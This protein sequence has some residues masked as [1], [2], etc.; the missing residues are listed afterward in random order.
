MRHEGLV[1]SYAHGALDVPLSDKT[2]GQV[3]TETAAR[4]ADRLAVVARHQAVRRTYAEFYADIDRLAC[5][6]HALGIRKGERVGIWSPN[7]Y[8]WLLVQFATS[9]LGIILVNVNPA[10]RVFE[11]EYALNKSGVRTLIAAPRFRT[12][13][14][15]AMLTELCPELAA[16]PAGGAGG[17]DGSDG[18]ARFA[19]LPQLR[20]VVILGDSA[21]PGAITWPDLLARA[22]ATE[23]ATVAAIAAQLQFDDP[24]NIQYTSGTTGFPKGVTLS[25]HNIVNNARYVGWAQRITAD[26]RICIP[27]PFY[28]C[29]GMVLSNMVA[30]C[31]GA[32]MIIPGEAFDPLAVLEA[33]AAERCT[34]LQGVPTMF[35]AELE[36]PEF[37][38]FDL[39]SLRTGIMAGAPCP[40]ELVRRVIDKMHMREFTIAYGQTELSPVVTQTTWDDPPDVRATT[41]GRPAPQAEIKIVDPVTGKVVPV[42]AQG[43]ICCRGYH[44]MLG[45]WDDPEA[46]ANTIDSSGWLHTG[47]L[48]TMDAHGYVKITGRSKEMVIRGGE[49]IY[50]RE[51]EEF[52]YTHPAIAEV[53]CFGVPD[54]KYGEEVCAWIHLRAGAEATA[55][56]I[57]AFCR[58]KI[59]TYKIPRYIKFVS[60]FPMTVT[61]KIQKFKMRAAMID[62]LG[63]TEAADIETA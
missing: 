41:V 52:L 45:Y 42:G 55:D 22:A 60:E 4:F 61:G 58:G 5:A 7:N 48:G 16:S 62:E 33:V 47:D 2:I 36:H 12:T 51:I 27:V 34:A 29:F 25:H 17:G 63:L 10:Y 3:L 56:E 11:L 44:V 14:Y 46:T 35:L 30:V 15:V 40:I 38:R 20:E 54:R 32:A 31:T 6:L 18:G 21:P 49:N 9:R 53:Q 13:D 50:P 24:V 57:R 8:E 39:G 37:D 19:R 28:H 23:P 26:D 1:Q 43:E 59:A